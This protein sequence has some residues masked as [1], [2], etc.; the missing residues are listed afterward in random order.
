LYVFDLL[1]FFTN[2]VFL[3]LLICA[4]QRKVMILVRPKLLGGSFYLDPVLQY[5]KCRNDAQ[6]ES[7]G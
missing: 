6:L 7:K 4:S 2:V 3:L 5:S 1:L